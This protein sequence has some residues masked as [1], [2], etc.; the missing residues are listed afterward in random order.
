M[1]RYRPETR[2]DESGDRVSLLCVLARRAPAGRQA[3][4]GADAGPRRS[5]AEPP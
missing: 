2:V 4:A 1:R 5:A 3:R